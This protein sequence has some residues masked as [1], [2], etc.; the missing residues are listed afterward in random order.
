MSGQTILVTGAGG[1]VGSHCI[2][3][4]LN[5]G[6]TIIA[7]DNLFNCIKDSSADKPE[8][9]I[10]VE[11]LTGK[12]ITFYFSD[13]KNKDSLKE[14]FKKHTIDCVIHCAALK[15]VGESCK[16]PL[17]YYSN[18]V[19]G[20]AN[21][22]EVMMEFNVKKIVFS[23]SSTVYGNPQYL[24]VD[25][26]HPTGNCTNPYGK[27]KY[28]ME[29]IMKDVAEANPEWGVMLLRYF[30]PVG[31][32]PSGEI[33]EDPLGIPN[34]LMPFISQVAVGRREKLMVYGSDYETPDG[35]GVRDY[36]H[37][38]DLATGH[39][40]ALNKILNPDFKG[41]KIYNLGTGQGCSV[42]EVVDAFE[43]ASGVKINKEITGRRLGDIAS[44]YCS[45]DLAEKELN[46]KSKF[47]IFDMCKDTWTWQSKNPKGFAKDQ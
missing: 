18:N 29:E 16:L 17:M 27:T 34:N 15:A 21:L 38:M 32:H 4:L 19:T 10:R 45:V 33:G 9:L 47:T 20:S 23:S 36:I 22:L 1:F 3:E 41:V 6:Y 25:E 11:K 35:S 7:V 24:P 26:K 44:S 39:A 43:K 31:A 46:F 42:L 5:E 13:L 28:F 8:S 12:S 37:I 30:N 2:I 14:V 40:S